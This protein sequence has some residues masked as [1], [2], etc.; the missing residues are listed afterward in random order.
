MGQGRVV[1]LELRRAMTGSETL[2]VASQ[3]AAALAAFAR[4]HRQLLQAVGPTGG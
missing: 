2:P 1:G 3:A 4:P